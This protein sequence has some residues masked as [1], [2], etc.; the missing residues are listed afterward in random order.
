[1]ASIKFNDSD[2]VAYGDELVNL[3][4]EYALKIDKFFTMLET[5]NN[6]GWTGQSADIYSRQAKNNRKK[7]EDFGKN[8]MQ[9]AVEIQNAGKLLSATEKKWEAK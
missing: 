2:L 4:K 6:T 8:M 9:Y 3:W 7:Y 5:I 1:M